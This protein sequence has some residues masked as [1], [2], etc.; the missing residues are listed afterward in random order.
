MADLFSQPFE[1]DDASP[2]EQPARTPSPPRVERRIRHRQRAD[3]RHP[4]HPRIVV[5]RRLGR[6][7]DLEL[8]GLEHRPRLLHAEGRRRADPRGD[9]PLGGAVS[10]VRAR[11]RAARHRPRPPRRLRAQGRVP[12]AVRAHA[13]AR[14]RRAAAR[15]RAA[16]KKLAAEGLFAAARKRPLPALPRKIGIVTSLDG[17]ALRDIIKVLQPPASQRAPGD[18]ARARAGGDGSRRDRAR[19]AGAGAGGGRRRRDRRARRR[20][21]RGPL[22]VQRGGRRAG[23]CRLP[24]SGHRRGRPRNRL[25]DRGLRRRPA[26]PDAVSRGGA[27][28]VRRKTS[29]ASAS[30][31]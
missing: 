2:Q 6:R 7:R 3:R 27:G 10:A 8:P 26:R 29:S 1:E 28:R 14:A 16:E 23:D 20:I 17:A 13:A 25:H 12:A 22:G 19:P 9:V 21:D 4:R 24:G 11:G 15:L 30:I 5:R 31:G 18:S